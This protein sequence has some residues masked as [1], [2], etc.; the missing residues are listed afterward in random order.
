MKMVVAIFVILILQ[1]TGSRSLASFSTP[2]RQSATDADGE[3]DGGSGANSEREPSSSKQARPPLAWRDQRILQ[4]GE[5]STGR[6][7]AGGVT[8]TIL[9]FG[10]GQAIHGRYPERGWIFT[11][12]E[13]AASALIL[14]GL[15]SCYGDRPYEDSCSGAGLITAGALGYIGFRVWELVDLWAA[16]PDENNR[17]YELLRLQRKS[18]AS[19]F[20]VLPIFPSGAL[21][22]GIAY[23]F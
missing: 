22:L 19:Q 7:I 12:G 2:E 21:G 1:L 18:R 5:I 8:G 10:I 23:N 13:L 15:V 4:R 14:A 17:Y 16:P 20:R 9:G 6:Y 3:E 11:A